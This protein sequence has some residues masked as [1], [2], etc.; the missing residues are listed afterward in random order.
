MSAHAA[1]PT[2]RTAVTVPAIARRKGD[3]PVVM[4]TAYDAPTARAADAAGVDI[5]LVGDSLA[6]VVLGHDTT[7]RVTMDEMLH[8]TAAVTRVRPRALVVGDMPYMSYH[9][10]REQAVTNAG[11]FIQE[12]GADAVKLEGG[13]SRVEL[14]AALGDAEIPVMGHV[15]LTPQSYH[16]MGGFRVQAKSPVDA[17]RLVADAEALAEA[18]V[19]ALVLE[20]IPREV[21]KLVTAAVDVPTIGIGAGP[22]CDGQVLVIH[23]ILGLAGE[24]SPRF[25]RRYAALG[26]AMTDAVQR[27]AAD[28]RSGAFPADGESYHLSPAG[29]Q[30]LTGTAG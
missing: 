20:G 16:R 18:G 10:S 9:V 5:L 15:G 11:R 26:E 7:L 13:A 14:I 12:G 17:K 1:T 19:F 28:V 24:R 23:D 6:M 3:E 2:T 27:F 30:E 21:A 25:V 4:V 8:H 22:D 29:A